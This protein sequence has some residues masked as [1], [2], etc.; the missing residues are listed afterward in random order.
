MAEE[1]KQLQSLSDE[2]QKLQDGRNF[3]FLSTL[4]LASNATSHAKK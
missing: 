3:Y 2:Y 1:Q 4:A